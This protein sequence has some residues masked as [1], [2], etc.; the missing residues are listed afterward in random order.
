LNTSS[1]ASRTPLYLTFALML[2]GFGSISSARVALSLYA[3][4]LGASASAVGILVGSLYVFPLLI[5]WPVGRYSD[6]VGS[7]WLLL[8]GTACGGGAL[9]IPYFVRELAALY[10]ASTLL[11]ISFTLY[12]VLLPNVVGLLSKPE[13]RARNFSNASLVG[14]TT[15]FVGPLLAGIAIDLSGHAAACLYLVALSAA[16]ATVLVVWGG[17][18]P[19]GGHHAGLAGS[20]RDTLADPAMLRILATSSL[21]QVG[22]DLY[23]FYIPVYGHGIGLSAS[24]IGGLL[25]TLAAA[26]FVVRFFLPR[27]VTRLGDEKVLALS[28]YVTA[29]G[30]GLVPFFESVVMLAVVSFVFGLGMGCGQP[31]TTMMI[32]S[33]SAAGRSGETLGLRQSVNNAMRVSGPAVFGFVATAF[34]LPPVFWISAVM[35]GGGGVLSR[36]P[37]NG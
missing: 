11:G 34:G 28:F 21:V 35:M 3:L 32:F 24:A 1:S 8:V 6:R 17:M 12:N 15:L 20:L 25:A 14:A 13:E 22:Q 4:D 27:L 9:L 23:Q 36:A 5:S 26:S 16:G 31:I 2:F 29:I 19:G 33:R 10:V 30:F 37:R 7:R 18:L